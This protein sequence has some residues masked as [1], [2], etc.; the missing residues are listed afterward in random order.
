MYKDRMYILVY[1]QPH[2]LH[3]Y[4]M[5]GQVVTK[6]NHN[7]IGSAHTKIAIV[8]DRLVIP[9]R[10]NHYLVV[11]SL[12]G[13][14]VK[15]ISC[16]LTQG[17]YVSMCAVGDDS[18]IVANHNLGR[19]F[20]V[21]IT[22][23][24]VIWTCSDVAKPEGVACYGQQHVLIASYGSSAIKILDAATGSYLI[25]AAQMFPKY[26]NRCICQTLRYIHS[27]W[28]PNLQAV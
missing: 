7:D 14:V 9:D 15:N 20:K 21:N 3:V 19:V 13:Q 26:V 16:Q 17:S 25:Y 11:Y 2:I 8:S 1:G 28:L 23:S 18:V 24:K 10:Q 12:T 5:V 22:T 6:C 27:K 4:N